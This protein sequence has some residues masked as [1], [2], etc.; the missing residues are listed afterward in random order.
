LALKADNLTAICELSIKCGSL[1]VSQSY[2]PP[3]PIT[4]IALLYFT[5][6]FNEIV[7]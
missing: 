7:K 1:E 3:R 2:R 5:L 4:G 6:K